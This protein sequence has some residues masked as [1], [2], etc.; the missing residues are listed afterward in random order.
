MKKTSVII[1]N[2]NGKKLLQQFLPSVLAHS[3]TDD[4]EVIVADNGSTDDSVSFL[5]THFPHVP[6]IL[7][8][9]NYGFAE[10]YNR[11]IEQVES[12]YVVLLNSDIEIT[13]NWLPPLLDYLDQHPEV[14]AVQPKI[15]DFFHREK[16]EYAGAAGGFIDKYGYPFCRGRILHVL[17]TDT[18]QY[19]D[20]VPI[21]WASGACMVIRRKDYLQAG[22]LDARFFAHQ[23]EIDLC[24]RLNARGKKMV[25][26]SASVV[27]HVGGASLDKEN[28]QKLYL[29]FRNNLLM[30]YKNEPPATL[31]STFS[32]RYL[33]DFLAF[34][35]LVLQGK[36]KN[37]QAVIRAHRDFLKMR[38]DY[39]NIRKENMEK[40]SVSSIPTRFSHSLLWKF[41]IHQQKTFSSLFRN[42][43]N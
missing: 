43:K 36:F 10:G 25:C 35:H 34:L 4:T 21:F 15:K 33:L 23:E 38:T 26:V 14:S 16:F 17:E 24:W 7:F 13:E 40:S 37:A 20:T 28:P 19:D 31:I 11:A 2:W 9:K 27:Y 41:Y 6:L 18:G 12:D 8:D 32:I 42:N 29:N 22:G 5:Q 1:L 39:Q 3:L 30:I